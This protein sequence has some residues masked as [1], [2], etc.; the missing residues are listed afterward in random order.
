M[1]PT[2]VQVHAP[3]VL[4]F[5]PQ[6]HGL[7]DPQGFQTKVYDLWNLRGFSVWM[8]WPKDGAGVPVIGVNDLMHLEGL[9]VY[10]YNL[11]NVM[12]SQRLVQGFQ[13]RMNNP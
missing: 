6:V 2:K 9:Q 12:R 4:V 1:I 10:M 13:V 3:G 8:D 5:Q 11:K 7:K